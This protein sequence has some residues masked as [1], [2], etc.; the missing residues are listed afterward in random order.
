MA[1][2]HLSSRATDGAYACGQ[3]YV[4]AYVK[5]A[6]W[7]PTPQLGGAEVQR[8][9]EANGEPRLQVPRDKAQGRRMN[10]ENSRSADSMTET[11]G[12]AALCAAAP[13]RRPQAGRS[14]PAWLDAGV[15]FYCKR[16]IS[17]A[18]EIDLER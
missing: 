3:S 11:A 1:G 17:F 18:C 13:C 14:R 8:R 6:A 2:L 12:G 15:G 5:A 7:L 16:T 10:D 9:S 4:L